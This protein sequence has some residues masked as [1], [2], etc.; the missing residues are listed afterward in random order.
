MTMSQ[1]HEAGG[2]V[3]KVQESTQKYARDLLLENERLVGAVATLHEEKVRLESRVR[4]LEE[5]V[6][7]R[8]EMQATLL[9]RIAEMETTTRDFT[10][11]YL[12]IEQLNA[13]LANLYVA[14]YR[15]HG[16]LE[17]KDVLETLREILI[18]LIGTENFAVFERETASSTLRVAASFGPAGGV[19][20]LSLGD[21]GL[22]A[23]IASGVPYLATGDGQP[24]NLPRPLA[25][26]VPLRVGDRVIG[27]IVVY[28]LL[29]HKGALEDGDVELFNLLAT[30]A[31]TALYCSDLHARASL[32]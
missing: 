13:N 16:S 17:R 15:L 2:Y 24:E 6:R 22:G 19:A 32:A 12:Q 8:E 21:P 1:K 30:H 29:A 27:A 31:A 7:S 4:G 28:E 14:S 11:R 9:E 3:R 5:R 25:A 10:E 26:C 20:S 23:R 18:N